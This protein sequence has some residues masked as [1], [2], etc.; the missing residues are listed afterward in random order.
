M[1]AVLAVLVTDCLSRRFG[2][3]GLNVVA[4]STYMSILVERCMEVW[5]D[6]VT[7]PAIELTG[8]LTRSGHRAPLSSIALMIVNNHPGLYPRSDEP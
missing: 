3:V 6:H 5:K 1:M 7:R 2:L 4:F 8:G